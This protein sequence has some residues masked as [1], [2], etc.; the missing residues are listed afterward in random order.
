MKNRDIA[1]P[2]SQAAP[3]RLYWPKHLGNFGDE[4]SPL[5][6]EHVSG[7]PVVHTVRPPRFHAIGSS[8]NNVKDE[9]VV[10]GSGLWYAGPVASRPR[11]TAVRGPLTRNHLLTQGIDCPEIYGDPALLLPL[12]H[13]PH[14]EKKTKLAVMPHR[15]DAGLYEQAQREGLP[16]I[17]VQD[18]PLHVVESIAACDMLVT[19]SLHGLIASDAYGI[20]AALLLNRAFL[21]VR[22]EFKY[23]DYLQSTGRNKHVWYDIPVTEAARKPLPPPDLPDRQRLIDA[24]PHDV[25]F[26]D[27]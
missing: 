24:F 1:S 14:F 21:E 12:I 20:P 16:V 27:V 8:L 2:A 13:T 7:R 22:P 5:I 6:V 3:I 11:I 15:L 25:R 18:D 10:W 17:S 26:E 4:L 9:D 19:S 23:H